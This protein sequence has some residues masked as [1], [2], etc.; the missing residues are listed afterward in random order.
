[1]HF[2][3][4]GVRSFHTNT[5]V[6]SDPKTQDVPFDLHLQMLLKITFMCFMR[7][8]VYAHHVY[9]WRSEVNLQRPRDS[10][11]VLRLSCKCLCL[12]NHLTGSQSEPLK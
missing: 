1:M 8:E 12:P 10:S 9:V 3:R 7:A 2:P 6:R 4:Y 5:K 11:Q